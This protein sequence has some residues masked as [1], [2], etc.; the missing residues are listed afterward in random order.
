MNNIDYLNNIDRV[1]DL[2]SY[3]VRNNSWDEIRSQVNR[4]VIVEVI[5]SVGDPIRT[6]LID[7]ARNYVWS[8]INE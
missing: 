7:N 3:Q 5:Y 4:E 6:E 8:Q 2:I 1:T